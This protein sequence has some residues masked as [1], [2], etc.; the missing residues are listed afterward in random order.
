MKVE[1][2]PLSPTPVPTI[3]L[4]NVRPGEPVRFEHDSVQDAL[5]SDLFFLKLDTPELKE[6]CRLVNLSDGKVIE[7]DWDHRMVVQKASLV[8]DTL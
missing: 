6:R 1:Q 7:R 8:L 2:R 5:K 3:A 4:K